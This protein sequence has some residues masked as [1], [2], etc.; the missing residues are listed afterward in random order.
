MDYNCAERH[1]LIKHLQWSHI[2]TNVPPTIDI[3]PFILHQF[4]GLQKL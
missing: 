4:E 1:Q 2:H 3:E